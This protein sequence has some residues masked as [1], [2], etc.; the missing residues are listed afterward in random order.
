MQ[1]MRIYHSNNDSPDSDDDW[2][3]MGEGW[4]ADLDNDE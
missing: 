3:G 4:D 1:F 2:D